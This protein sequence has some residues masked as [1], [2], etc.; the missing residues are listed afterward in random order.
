MPEKIIK[1]RACGK[2]IQGYDFPTRMEKLRRHYK[3]NHP[4]LWKL[5]VAKSLATKIRRGIIHKVHDPK[6][7]KLVA[8]V[9]KRR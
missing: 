8:K 6:W 5:S 9:R 3:E 4:R 2:S 1:C 7:Q